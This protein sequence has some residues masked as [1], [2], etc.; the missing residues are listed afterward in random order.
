MNKRTYHSDPK[1]LLEQ[2]QE[3]VKTVKDEHYRH[4]VEVVNFVLSG[5]FPSEVAPLVKESKSTITRW[6]R[7]VD[8]KGWDALQDSPNQG[9]RPTTLTEKEVG[10]IDI[11]LQSNP[12]KYGYD[13]WDGIS[14]SHFI[15][16][17][18]SIDFS[19]RSCQRLF[20]EL[21]YSRIRPQ[22]FPCKGDESTLLREEFKKRMA[23]LMED[24]NAILWLQDEVHFHLQTSIRETWAKK[25]SKPKIKSNPKQQS[26]SYSGFV[27]PKTGRFMA[28]KIDWFNYETTIESLRDFNKRVRLKDGQK[29]YLVMDN[30]P[31]HKKAKRLIQDENNKEYADLR[32][33]I[34][35]VDMPPYSP[36]LN[37]IEQVWRVTRR[38]VTHNRYWAS[39]AELTAALDEYFYR[40]KKPNE[41]FSSLCSFDFQ[42]K[43]KIIRPRVRKKFRAA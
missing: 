38:E 22:P 7:T 41:K 42:K 27:S 35:F 23:E 19:V 8:E 10:A 12:K 31:W 3:L 29:I 40:F 32:K 20:H 9:G 30:A 4:K 2:G 21:G 24:P 11:A 1:I 15:K 36:D 18:F 43:K 6:V 26:V 13:V 14:L 37:P 28:F 34:V 33:R 5:M 17:E 16:K 25:G 39:L